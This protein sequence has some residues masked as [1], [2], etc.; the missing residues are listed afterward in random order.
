MPSTRDAREYIEKLLAIAEEG[1]EVEAVGKELLELREVVDT[2]A[3]VYQE[4]DYQ[5]RGVLRARVETAVPLSPEQQARLQAALEKIFAAPV[6]LEQQI[7][8]DIIAG[9]RV[10]IG[11][12]VIDNS[13]RRRLQRMVESIHQAPVAED[14]G[15]SLDGGAG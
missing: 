2:S 9:L 5:R 1:G 8:A 11:D 6:A 12:S 15:A 3:A 7:N 13:L 10:T 4:L 14:L